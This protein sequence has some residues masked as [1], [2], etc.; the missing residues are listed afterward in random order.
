MDFRRPGGWRLYPERSYLYEAESWEEAQRRL[1]EGDELLSK[2]G[3]LDTKLREA[4]RERRRERLRLHRLRREVFGKDFTFH[5]SRRE[6]LQEK[7]DDSRER[8]N[9]LHRRVEE[10]QDK[11]EQ[12]AR[13]LNRNFFSIQV[14]TGVPDLTP[15]NEQKVAD[16]VGE[17]ADG[18]WY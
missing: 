14:A 18:E 8:H 17:P 9:E 7:K 2:L 10:L 4:I 15:P 3:E 16:E 12:I 11:R 13:H 1:A 5:T 6:E